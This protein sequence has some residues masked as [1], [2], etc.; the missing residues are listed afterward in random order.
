M[1]RDATYDMEH[2]VDGP[3]T[4]DGERAGSLREQVRRALD[5]MHPALQGLEDAVTYADGLRTGIAIASPDDSC[6]GAMGNFFI[7]LRGAEDGMERVQS[8][9][10]DIANGGDAR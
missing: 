2:A 1:S 6:V 4:A 8:M 9:L 10:D 3:V 5:A 7:D